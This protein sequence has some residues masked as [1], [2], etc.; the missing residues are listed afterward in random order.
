V[1]HWPRMHPQVQT[2]FGGGRLNTRGGARPGS[3]PPR[4]PT[5]LK[6]VQG[7]PGKRRLPQNEPKPPAAA[8]EPPAA[9]DEIGRAFWDRYAPWL[10]DKGLLTDQD[11]PLFEAICDQE[12][13]YQR[14]ALRLRRQPFGKVAKDLDRRSRTALTQRN[15]MLREFGFSPSQ[16]TRL[17]V[18]AP[19]ED[20]FEDFL[21]KAGS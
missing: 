5:A 10:I 7:N 21:S 18:T 17:S 8:Y 15:Q 3:G 12:S 20:P 1:P 9:L 13:L 11:V 2:F 6:I 14:L 4:K 19:T 16:R